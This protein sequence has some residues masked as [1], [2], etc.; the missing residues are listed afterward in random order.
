M[1]EGFSKEAIGFLADLKANNNREWFTEHKKIY[2]KEIKSPTRHFCDDM[3][4]SLRKL[5]GT[6]HES[7]VFRI[8]RDVRFSKDKTPYNA[9]LHISF[10]PQT[11]AASPPHWFFG[12]DPASLTVGVGN[13]IFEKG[14]LEVYRKR[15]DG[16]DGAALSKTLTKLEKNG[17]RLGKTDLKRVP[18]P[19][20]KDH[21]QGDLLKR[22][23]LSAWIDFEDA[24]AALDKSVIKTCTA[25]FK[26][27]KPVYDW[28][29]DL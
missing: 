3:A 1:F 18:P 14:Q 27:I 9:H 21:P 17:V 20:D 22:K 25:N 13:F 12:L 24:S 2:E 10:I 6:P 11:D 23:G 4:A 19:F 16:K 7:K 5:T 15:V 26:K 8:H 28:L 29:M